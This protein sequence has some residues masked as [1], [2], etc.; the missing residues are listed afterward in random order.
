[1]HRFYRL[2][3]GRIATGVEAEAWT[4]SV[5]DGEPLQQR[6]MELTGALSGVNP[7]L[8]RLFTHGPVPS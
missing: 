7:Q 6:I 8:A 5:E 2:L 4:R 1:M 3:F